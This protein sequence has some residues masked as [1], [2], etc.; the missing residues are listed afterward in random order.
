MSQYREDYEHNSQGYNTNQSMPTMDLTTLS[1]SSL[2]ALRDA[3]ESNNLLS[4]MQASDYIHHSAA[5]AVGIHCQSEIER[6]VKW[7]CQINPSASDT[8]RF[9]IGYAGHITRGS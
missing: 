2:R 5:T 6:R 9:K 1:D 4:L 8:N 3:D 7:F